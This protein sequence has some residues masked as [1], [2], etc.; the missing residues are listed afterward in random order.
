[1][2]GSLAIS[3]E[4][5]VPSR[6]DNAHDQRREREAGRFSRILRLPGEV[7]ADSV[8][9]KR[10]DGML[11]V[12]IAKADAAKPRKMRDSLPH[13]PFPGHS[14]PLAAHPR[15]ILAGISEHLRYG[16]ACDKALAP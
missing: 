2:K 10:V 7:D 5:S 12:T 4:R 9:A 14:P 6:R 3:G 1:M 11:T 8:D 15:F 16:K 13:R